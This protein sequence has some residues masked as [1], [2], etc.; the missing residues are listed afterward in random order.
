MKTDMDVLRDW[1]ICKGVPAEYLD[2]L[3]EPPVLRDIGEGLALSLMNDDSI[4]EMIV[5]ML[6]RQDEMQAEIV[7][8][9]EELQ[10]LKG[11]SV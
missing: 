8:L 3:D 10:T 1:L 9:R 6:M 11:G 4:G 2:E 7:S 5:M